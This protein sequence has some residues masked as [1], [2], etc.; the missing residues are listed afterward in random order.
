MKRS[1]LVGGLLLLPLPVMFFALM[2]GRYPIS[3]GEVFAALT[4]GEVAEVVRALV[5][6]IRLPRIGAAALVGAN[7]AVAGAVYQ[8]VFRN[9]LVEGRLLGVSSGAGLG[10]A[11]A[12]LLFPQP[13]VVQAFAFAGGALGVALTALLGWT[14]GGGV[15]VLVIAGVL[16]DSFLSAVLGL[17]KYAADPLGTLP[18]ITYWLLGGL[19][20]VR[21]PDLLPLGIASGIGLSFFLLAR[22]R[23]NLLTLADQ[24]AEAL[25]VRVRPTRFLVVGMG[26]LLVA[27]AVSVSGTVSWVGLLVPHAARAVVG[28]DYAKLLPAAAGLGA[29]LVVALDTLA[30]TLL[31]AE[32]PLGILTGLLGAPLF[33]VLF[34]RFLRERGGWR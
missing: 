32:I 20:G 1:A 22:W 12:F 19:S 13:A 30:R 3:P 16:V 28:P 25:G 24:E 29:A 33:L 15:L 17:V 9:P 18:A 34:L 2:V 31:T 5:L 4:G 7:L 26:T 10:A 8:G 27:S 11:L 23:L 6:R 21:V 14:F